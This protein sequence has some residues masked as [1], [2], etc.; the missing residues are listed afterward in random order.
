MAGGSAGDGSAARDAPGA[1][2]EPVADTE[3]AATAATRRIGR[4]R[5]AEVTGHLHALWYPGVHED[6]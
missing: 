1:G 2:D 4:L 6:R 3:H 5:A